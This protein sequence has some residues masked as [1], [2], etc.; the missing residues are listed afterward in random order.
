MLKGSGAIAAATMTSRVLGLAREMVYA[1]FMGNGAVASAFFLAFSIPNLFRRLLGEG[2]L[3]AA[4]IPIFKR[5]Q[6]T[7]GEPEMW[8]AANVVISG[9]LAAAL[10]ITVVAIGILSAVLAF[11]ALR[12]ERRLMIELLRLM[13]PY[14]LL[15]C[16]A[17]VFIG[18]ANARGHFFVPALGATML[19]VVM[20]GSVWFLAPLMG[21]RLDQ[22]IFGLA[23]G[24]LVAGLFQAIFQ[25]PTLRKEGFRYQWVSPWQDPVVREV[26][27]KMLPGAMGVAAFQI[28]VLVTQVFAYWVEET[29]VSTFNYAVRLMELPQGLFGIS[30]ATYLLPTLSGLAA[31]KNY[32]EF[33][34]TLGQG[35]GHLAFANIFAS[36]VSMGLAVP[37]V[38][39]L[40]ERGDFSSLATLRVAT[41]L[42]CL[43]PGL[44]MFSMNNI[45]ARAFYAL[46]DIRTP[47]RIS[48]FC[49]TLNIG[50]SLCLVRT[51]RE[52][53]LGAAN[54]ITAAC[55]TAL[56]LYSLRI[57]L[58]Q[59]DLAGW[60]RDLLV[61]AIGGG[62]AGVLA[63]LVYRFWDAAL[64]HAT[65]PARIGAVFIPMGLA[66][67]LYA[68]WAFWLRVP[69]AAEVSRFLMR[70]LKRP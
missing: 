70:K 23:I 66:G 15:V 68:G 26:L 14:M 55:N 62:G 39:L 33:R 45:L 9:L 43:A 11:A 30:L 13:F 36:T 22:Q 5:K 17:A 29:I 12:P 53:G 35:L 16:L 2:A 54:S 59:L 44:L 49:L 57:K 4:F 32:P 48:I 60:G 6:V 34:G 21:A 50:L 65:L 41:A 46:D 63:W 18:M 28:N 10:V 24:V 20:I 3:T 56:L 8:R 27:R 47:M 37:I 58:K 25:L 1:A 61:L 67:L 7:E 38:R 69:A 31:Q 40:F 64:G 52:A 51:F 19:N 42:A